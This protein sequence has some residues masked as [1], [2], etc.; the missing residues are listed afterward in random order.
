MENSVWKKDFGNEKRKQIYVSP[1]IEQF[2]IVM[3]SGIAAGSAT[4]SPGDQ[5]NPNN[6]AVDDWNNGGDVGGGTNSFD[7]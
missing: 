2:A 7:F 1:Q 5:G 4:L 6:P 3:E